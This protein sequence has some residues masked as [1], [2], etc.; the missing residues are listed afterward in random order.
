MGKMDVTY[1]ERLLLLYIYPVTL[2]RSYNGRK[3]SHIER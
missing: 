1:G 2:S 3:S